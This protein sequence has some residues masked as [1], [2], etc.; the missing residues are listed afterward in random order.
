MLPRFHLKVLLGLA[1]MALSFSA[2]A[3]D[4]YPSEPI[5]LIV[6]YA[7]GASTDTLARMVAQDIT[8]TLK[9]PVIVENHAG[10][11]GSIAAD[12]TKRQPA[13]GYTFM[14]STDGILCINP[15]VYKKL[16]YDPVKDFTSL[17]IA[18]N[19]P[20]VL[21]VRANSPFKT[22][23]DLLAY[24][25]ANPGKL[26]YGSA[27]VGSSQN[28]AG[29]LTKSMAG[30]NITHVPYRG[31]SPAMSDLLGGHIDMMFVQVASAYGLYKKGSLRLLAVGS[32]NRIKQLP[33]VPTFDE[34]GLKGYDSDTWYGFSFPTH[35]D[36]K[37]V[38]TVNA[39]IVKSLK[40][41]EATLEH[42]GYMVVGSTPQQ[43]DAAIKR[44]LVKWANVAKEIGIYHKQ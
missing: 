26:S 8:E 42:L 14:L 2:A 19:A 13:D 31:G 39:A 11:G 1:S 21:A 27:G 28:M 9:Q 22:A 5:K 32:P 33:E 15:A 7:A 25:K 12:Y 30:V 17:T 38:A 36:P 43:Q 23:T 20:I 41:R 3:A 16:N 35:V 37:I 24:A 29:E 10:A 34:L 6:P 18:V 40:H 44:N 4:K